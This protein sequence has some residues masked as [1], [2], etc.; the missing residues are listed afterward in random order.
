MSDPGDPKMVLLA[1]YNALLKLLLT[2]YQ[3]GGS[4]SLKNIV[5]KVHLGLFVASRYIKKHDLARKKTFI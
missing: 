5:K 2:F 1:G 3:L 4:N